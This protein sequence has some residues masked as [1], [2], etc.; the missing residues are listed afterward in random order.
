MD[1][2]FGIWEEAKKKYITDLVTY[3]SAIPKMV[4]ITLVGNG[5]LTNPKLPTEQDVTEVFEKLAAK[6]KITLTTHP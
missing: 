1:D 2:A 5:I 4:S 6:I 3:H